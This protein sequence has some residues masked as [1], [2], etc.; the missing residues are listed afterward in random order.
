MVGD[1]NS[2]GEVLGEEFGGAYAPISRL[3]MVL[4]W[5][6]CGSV[7]FLTLQDPSVGGSIRSQRIPGDMFGLSA[8]RSLLEPGM[9]S[10]FH[11]STSLLYFMP[12]L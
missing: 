8:Q 9:L 12:Q 4:F 5:W 11:D 1:N 2:L 6:P 7:S 10:Y 3:Y